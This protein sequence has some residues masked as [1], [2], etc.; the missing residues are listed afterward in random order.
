[1]NEKTSDKRAAQSAQK[2]VRVGISHGDV[3]SISYE[4]I[5]KALQPKDILDLFS[6]IIFGSSKVASYN[7]KKFQ[8]DD[9]PLNLVKGAALANPN[10]T[11]IINITD[12]EVSI[13]YGKST[14]EAGALALS[15]LNKAIEEIYAGN[16]DVLV[17]GPINKQNIQSDE[18]HFPG[19]TEYLAKKFDTPEE[20]VLMLLIHKNLRVGV[21]TGHIPISEVSDALTFDLICHKARVMNKSLKQDFGVRKPRIAVLSVNPH[22]GDQGLIGS[23]EQDTII[24]AIEQLKEEGIL[25]FG[26]YPSDGFFGSSDYKKFDAILGMYHDQGLV[27]FKILSE[28]EGVNF[29]AGLPIVRTSPAHGTAFGIAGEGVASELSLRNACFLAVEIYKN[30][31]EETELNKNPLKE[32]PYSSRRS[33]RNDDY[34]E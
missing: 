14:Q 17:T 21:V 20:D 15:S 22:A 34:I 18:F 32:Q 10:R 8:L 27:P 28:G 12:Q 24:P 19:H 6:P 7:K 11:N 3:N 26:P 4:V 5:L 2:Q 9:M 25:A 1:M 29:T 16:I 33:S 30:R 13:E 23:D 31:L